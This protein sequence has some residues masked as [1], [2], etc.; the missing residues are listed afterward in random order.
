[1]DKVSESSYQGPGSESLY[2]DCCASGWTC[3]D[4]TPLH[5]RKCFAYQILQ[6]IKIVY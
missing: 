2:I 1:M 5:K 6:N 3:V 4:Y